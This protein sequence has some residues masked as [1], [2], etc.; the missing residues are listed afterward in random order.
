MVRGAGPL[1]DGGC[2]DGTEPAGQRGRNGVPP[3][4]VVLV[5]GNGEVGTGIEAGLAI[6]LGRPRIVPRR[7][8]EDRIDAGR[9][10]AGRVDAAG[11]EGDRRRQGGRAFLIGV[12]RGRDVAHGRR[13]RRTERHRHPRRCSSRLGRHRSRRGQGHL[14]EGGAR[15]HS[16]RDEDPQ[17]PAVH[18]ELERGHG[19]AARQGGGRTELDGRQALPADGPPGPGGGPEHRQPPRR[20]RSPTGARRRPCRRAC[21]LAGTRRPCA[22]RPVN[23]ATPGAPELPGPRGREG[24]GTG[25]GLSHWRRSR[26]PARREPGSRRNRGSRRPRS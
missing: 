20:R 24:N 3:V 6:E 5:D 19:L 26:S 12:G 25:V 9:V 10:D 7:V 11:I 2:R 22:C 17:R 4:L 18:H 23:C 15:G 16:G 13:G 21:R 8:V 14:A 1:A